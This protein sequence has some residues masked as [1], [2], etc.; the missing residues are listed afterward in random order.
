MRVTTVGRDHFER[1]YAN[2]PDPWH[3]QT[4]GYERA[5]Y[6]AT[7]AALPQPRY[8]RG[9][10]VGCSIG[11]L[12]EALA[13]RCD[14][15]LAVEPVEAALAQ[16]KARNAA[17]G[18][19][20]FASMMIPGD[21]PDE[22]FDLIVISE[23]LD[24]LGAADLTALVGRLRASLAPGG[25]LLMVHWVAKKGAMTRPGEATDVLAAAAGDLLVP[26]EASRN[27]DYR[28]DVFRRS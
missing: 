7:L 5:K 18:H 6:G 3:Y 10:D 14:D 25:D 4:S 20:R 21:W 24:Y 13:R 26:L 11:V 9:L 16:A 19:V 15:L 12:T 2:R 27:G 8:A 28:L 22:M 1:L 17:H 23:V